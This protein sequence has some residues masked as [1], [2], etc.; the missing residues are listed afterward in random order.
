MASVLFSYMFP[1]RTVSLIT[2]THILTFDPLG[3]SWGLYI[4]KLC[5]VLAI[6]QEKVILIVCPPVIQRK[7]NPLN[8]G[9]TVDRL[10]H[11]IL[12][13]THTLLHCQCL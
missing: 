8:N 13:Q 5:P 6:W 7:A 4:Q 3:S 1:V 10:T 9:P 12:G 2:H 11:C